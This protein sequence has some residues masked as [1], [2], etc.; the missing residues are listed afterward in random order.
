[1]KKTKKFQKKLRYIVR[2]DYFGKKTMRYND[3]CKSVNNAKADT[4]LNEKNGGGHI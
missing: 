1:M 4:L 3:M 2:T